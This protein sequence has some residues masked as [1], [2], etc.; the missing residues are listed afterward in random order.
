MKKSPFYIPPG[1]VATPMELVVV[2]FFL[3]TDVRSWC[4]DVE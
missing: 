3:S 4:D 2:V 1:Y